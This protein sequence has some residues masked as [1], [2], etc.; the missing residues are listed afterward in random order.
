[1][2]MIFNIYSIMFKV[3]NG[4]KNINNKYFIFLFLPVKFVSMHTLIHLYDRLLPITY[5]LNN[6]FCTG[7]NQRFL[8]IHA[9]ILLLLKWYWGRSLT[10][11]AKSKND[12]RWKKKTRKDTL[13]K[14]LNNNPTRRWSLVFRPAM[15]HMWYPSFCSC[16]LKPGIKYFR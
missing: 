4:P 1:M 5:Y 14:V 9:I 13:T 15:L 12:K 16:L 2:T 10:D 8:I 11:N 3:I 6:R 7:V